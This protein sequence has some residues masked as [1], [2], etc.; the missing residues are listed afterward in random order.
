MGRTIS[1]KDKDPEKYIRY[2][3]PEP[4]FRYIIQLECAIINNDYENLIKL[5]PKRFGPDWETLEWDSKYN[6]IQQ[7]VQ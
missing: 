1:V 6:N 3:V 7:G 5:Y 2:S 4:I